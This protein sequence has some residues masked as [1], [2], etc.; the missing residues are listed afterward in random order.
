MRFVILADANPD[1]FEKET[2]EALKDSLEITDETRILNFT[3]LFLN[4]VQKGDVVFNLAVGKR[5][6]FAQGFIA[7]ALESYGVEFV[8]SPAY[9]HYVCLDKFTTKS[10][11]SAYGIS[12]PGGAIYDGKKW[13][14]KIPEPPLIV[15]PSSE[16][17]GIGIDEKS[18]CV[19]LE[20]A[21]KVAKEK[22]QE[23]KEPILVEKYIEGKEITVGVLGFG[24]KIEVLPPLEIDFSN[25]P[26]GIERYYS[27]RVKEEYAQQTIYRCPAELDEE[28]LKLVKKTA[29]EVFK[30]V[31][32]RDFIRMDMRVSNGIP[33]VI[34]VNSRPGLHPIMS[35]IPKMVKAISKD[36]KWLIKTITRRAVAS[37]EVRNG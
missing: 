18:L 32:A 35:D 17:S 6:D 33:H 19:D 2:I 12:T 11:L 4:E 9:T 37:M 36:Y 21:K 26:Q 23:F 5:H 24:G 29:I 30:V 31:R 22:Y 27:K 34:E 16:G 3:P 28:T 1:E 7:A 13:R 14:G 8:G 15:K 20:N 25:L 10:L